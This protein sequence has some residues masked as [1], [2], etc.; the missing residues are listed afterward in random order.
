MKNILF[1]ILCIT[2]KGSFALD[3]SCHQPKVIEREVAG[4]I[5]DFH[6]GQ[7]YGV[8]NGVLITTAIKPVIEGNKFRRIEVNV[9]EKGSFKYS[10]EPAV[11]ISK[12]SIVFTLAGHRN[13]VSNYELII[14]YADQARCPTISYSY[15]GFIPKI[16]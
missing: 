10:F 3:I 15:K 4:A 1:Y 13:F 11:G 7:H 6:S 14:T 16:K 12:E 9:I 5:I 8:E 2:A